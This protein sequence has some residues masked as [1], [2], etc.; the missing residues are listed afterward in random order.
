MKSAATSCDIFCT[1]V[2]NY[3][4][5]GVCW[6]L[7]RQLANE[8]GLQVRLWVDDLKSF[9]RLCPDANADHGRQICREV[10]V[11]R[12][13]ADFPAVEPADLVIEAFA[14]RL[15]ESYVQA[16]AAREPGPVWVN[17]EYLSAEDWVDGSHGLPSPHPTLPLTRYFF[18][19]GFTR[20]T[21]GLLLEHDL[22]ARRDA[23][24]SDAATQG[25]YWQSL[26]VPERQPGELRVSLFS[27]ENEAIEDLLRCWE[28]GD[29]LV[30]CLLPEGRSLPQVAAFF[31]YPGGKAG[32][33]WQRGKLRVH[34]LPF[35]EQ[36]RYD[37]LLWA[38]DV[39]FVRGEDSCVRAQWADR[40]FIWHIYPQHD[41]VHL[42]KLE[43]LR[44]RYTEGLPPEAALAVR[45]LWRAWNGGPDVAGSWL[46]FYS[47][48]KVLEGRSRA[49][50]QWLASNNLALN[51][52][53]FYR[54]TE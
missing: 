23:F 19:P 41:G 29:Q 47:Q 40:P 30:T 36:E 50:A 11:R 21:G 8:H 35:V 16:M 4:D 28:R 49:W 17:L 34:V 51:L 25:R 15:P 20:Q 31:G 5:I 3:G 44:L 33:V 45:N 52:L 38:C 1:V 48:Y 53:A 9:G 24:Q 54:Q 26:G 2:D 13:P 27:Y 46:R 42:A 6:R 14:C 10:E 18:F 37:E 12:W 32:D 39:N 22:L 43:A 7:A